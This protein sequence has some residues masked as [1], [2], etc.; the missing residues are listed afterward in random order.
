[1]DD[2][3]RMA[4]YYK[5]LVFFFPFAQRAAEKKKEKKLPELFGR[6]IINFLPLHPLSEKKKGGLKRKEI[7]D[8]IS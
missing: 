1:M 5:L 7:F 6:Y 8:R 3:K 2:L 4:C